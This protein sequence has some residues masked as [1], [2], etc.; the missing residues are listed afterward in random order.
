MHDPVTVLLIC[1]ENSARSIIGEAVLRE[2]GGPCVEV[3]S[4]GVYQ[5]R[6]NPLTIVALND[7]GYATAGLRSKSISEVADTEFDYVITVCDEAE[8]ACPL[9][10]NGRTEHV[11]WHLSD[12][13]A[14]EG[15]SLERLQAFKRT[16][17]DVEA[18]AGGF[19]SVA[20]RTKMR[21]FLRRCTR[22]ERADLAVT[23]T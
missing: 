17:T 2:R 18:R 12:P 4:A 20:V 23:T 15:S 16:V 14:A 3:T 19:L 22:S 7:A 10:P 11:R 21:R 8:A 9:W 1:V 5:T 13:A 6:V